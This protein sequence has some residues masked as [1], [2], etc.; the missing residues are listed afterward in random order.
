MFSC[1]LLTGLNP[2][3]NPGEPGKK[4]PGFLPIFAGGTTSAMQGECIARLCLSDVC[5]YTTLLGYAHI[6]S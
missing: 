3:L 6:S 4:E 2:S 5:L 1:K